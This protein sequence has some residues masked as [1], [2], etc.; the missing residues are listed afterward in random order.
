MPQAGWEAHKRQY[1]MTVRSCLT[2]PRD[3]VLLCFQP[4]ARAVGPVSL[5]PTQDTSTVSIFSRETSF[6]MQPRALIY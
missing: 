2:D 4:E 3:M 5:S 6:H 1:P